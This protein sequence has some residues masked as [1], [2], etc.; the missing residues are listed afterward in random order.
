MIYLR[1]LV[2]FQRTFLIKNTAAHTEPLSV[3][4]P[5]SVASKVSQGRRRV[6]REYF[7]GIGFPHCFPLCTFSI[8]DFSCDT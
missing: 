1:P 8:P 3:I 7:H 5:L 2:G 4:C 6:I